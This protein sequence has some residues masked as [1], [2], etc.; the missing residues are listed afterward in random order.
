M[1]ILF[2]KREEIMKKVIFSLLVIPAVL[3]GSAFCDSL[4]VGNVEIKAVRLNEPVIVDGIL[5]EPVWHNGGEL[6]DFTQREP[7][8]GGEATERTE[9][10][11]AYDDDALY[12]GAR[13]HD[14]APDSIIA[15]MGRR[16]EWVSAD[17]V[18]FYIDPYYDRRSGFWS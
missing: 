9:I 15:R 11:I 17:F 1:R 5:S 16:D 7:D 14:S 2:N 8:E 10:R 4:S 18:R 13:M 3:Y 12:V 6:C